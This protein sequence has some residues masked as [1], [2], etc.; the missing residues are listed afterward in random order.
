MFRKSCSG[1]FLLF[2]ELRFSVQIVHQ[3]LLRQC[4]TKKDNEIWILLKSNDLRFSK[5]FAL[6]TGLSFGSI[7]KCDQKSLWIRDIYFKGENKV[8][9]GELKKVF[10]Y[11]GEVKEKEKEKENKRIWRW[12]GDKVGTFVFSRACFIWERK[13][14]F[15][16]YA[17]NCSSW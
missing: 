15:N 6:I 5:E 10:L 7:P 1:H 8:H 17:M 11:L 9:N 16:R 2:P 13:E 14:K 12:K 3:L 4:E